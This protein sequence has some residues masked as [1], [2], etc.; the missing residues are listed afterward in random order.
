MLYCND[1]LVKISDPEFEYLEKEF[2]KIRKM[3]SPIRIKTTQKTD[4]N[5]T[6][7]PEPIP[8][9]SWP[10]KAN[11]TNSKG[12]SETWVYTKSSPTIR[13]GRLEF[14]EKSFTIT[15]GF[16][17]ID[18]KKETEKAYF[19]LKLSGILSSGLFEIEDLDKKNTEEIQ[20]VGQNSA[21]EFFICNKFSPIYND[22]KRIKSLAASWGVSGVDEMHIDTVRKNLLEKVNAGQRNYSVTKRGM[23]EF[24]KEVNGED[25]FSEY[26]TL[27]QLAID[28]KIIVWND[29]DKGWYLS[30]KDS[31]ELVQALMFIPSIQLS[32]KQ[33]MLLDYLRLNASIFA[34]IKEEVDNLTKDSEKAE[35]NTDNQDSKIIA[36]AKMKGIK[37]KGK[38]I[39]EITKELQDLDH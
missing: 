9:H 39:E 18:P 10:L 29:K 34:M 28:R 14:S 31:G 8:A 23:D 38:S 19:I 16:L 37:T 25:P 11:Y 5:P 30:D 12:Q 22:H 24:V 35:E 1:E 32:Q 2:E 26:R 27:V 33:N 4:I 17:A 21:V 36:R 6:G 13:D 20:K 3:K 7:F 15:Q